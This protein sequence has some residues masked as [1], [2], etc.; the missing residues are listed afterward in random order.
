MATTTVQKW[1]NSYAV[2][3]PRESVRR[4]ALQAGARVSISESEH[5][6]ALTV[7]PVRERAASL[8]E[9]VAR[10]SPKNRHEETGWDG[11]V[12]KEAW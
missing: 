8:R 12:G 11:A 5:G 6:K 7:T 9:L 3:L 1:G 4:L 10:I 2:R